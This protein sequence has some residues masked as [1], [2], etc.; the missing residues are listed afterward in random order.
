MVKQV[1][2]IFAP[3]IQITQITLKPMR[4]AFSFHTAS[5]YDWNDILRQVEVM[6]IGGLDNHETWYRGCL[7][8]RAAAIESPADEE[9]L[10][11]LWLS[12]SRNSGGY[13]GDRDVMAQWRCCRAPSRITPGTII[14]H[15]RA[16]GVTMSR[17]RNSQPYMPRRVAP[18][19]PSRSEPIYYEETREQYQRTTRPEVIAMS[20]L[21]QFLKTLY[22]GTADTFC[23][24][25]VGYDGRRTMFRYLDINHRLR[26]IKAMAYCSDGHRDK[27]VHPLIRHNQPRPGQRAELVYFGEHLLAQHPDY[28]VAIVESEKTALIASMEIPGVIWLATGSK[29][30]LSALSERSVLDGRDVTLHPD[31][32]AITDW[33]TIAQQRHWHDASLLIPD[34]ASLLTAIAPTADIAD[35]FVSKSQSIPKP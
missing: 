30:N 32:D 8:L 6:H 23:R 31:A 22:P 9:T 19:V 20:N 10:R 27:S 7:S 14:A 16:Q 5:D 1:K 3:T 33:R 18:V 28:P 29:S 15:L 21:Y 34:Y 12:L 2:L 13:T 25:E 35:Y 11:E 24:Y 26:Q 4:N 17:G